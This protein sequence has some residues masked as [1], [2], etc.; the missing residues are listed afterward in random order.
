GIDK[1]LIC[2]GATD[3]WETLPHNKDGIIF[4]QNDSGASLIEH[5]SPKSRLIILGGGHIAIPLS[6]FGEKVGFDVTVFDDRPSFANESRFPAAKTV[7]CEAFENMAQR[8]KI[9]KSDYIVIVTR[10]H[11][12]DTLCLRSIL[13]GDFPRYVG[14]IGSRRRVAIVKKQ[15]ED[16]TGATSGLAR[17]Y[18]PVGLAIGAVTPE[19]I[20]ASIIAEIIQCKRQ[21]PE[22][23]RNPTSPEYGRDFPPDMELLGWLARDNPEKAALVTV[24]LTKGSTP[25]ETGAKMAVLPYGQ[26]IG[27]IGGGC[28]EAEVIQKARTVMQSG[29][30]QVVDVDMTDSAEDDGMVCG[31]TM[32]VLI[33][34][35]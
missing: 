9:R 11:R 12:H 32:K 22:S 26:V 20:A 25:R 16:E 30:Y 3:L 7:I 5:Y 24:V 35:V 8:L 4:S 18:S 21:N 23:R 17:L 34:A 6:F 31:G 28:A 10:G 29:A 15:L 14:M 33:E 27:S 13:R 1:T 19:E 2:E